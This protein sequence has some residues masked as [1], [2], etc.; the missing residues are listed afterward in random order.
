MF[1]GK[2]SVSVAFL[3]LTAAICGSQPAQAT[4]PLI[5][6]GDIIVTMYQTPV[7]VEEK[8]LLTVEAG[9]QLLVK[10]VQFPGPRTRCG[11]CRPQ[12]GDADS[13]RA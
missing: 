1:E 4:E 10:A 11:L 7:K 3:V 6:V 13:L 8:T 5:E 12:L 2:T 9:T